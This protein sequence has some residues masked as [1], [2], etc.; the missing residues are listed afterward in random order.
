[1]SNWPSVGPAVPRRATGV[2]AMC[3]LLLPV[4]VQAQGLDTDLAGL[5]RENAELY[6]A[7]VTLGLGYAMGGGYFDSA[8]AMR[9]F[10]FDVG[11]RVMGALPSEASKTF[12]A[13]LPSTITFEGQTFPNPY[14]IQG[15][16]PA[17]PTATGQGPGIVLEPRA[18]FLE[19]LEGEGRNP[20]D[21]LIRFPEGADLPVIPYFVAHASMG[22][23]WGTEISARLMPEVELSDE[24]GGASAFGFGVK[25]TVSHWLAEPSPIDVAVWYG[26]QNVKVG[27]YLDGNTNQYGVMAGRGFGPLSLYGTGM[28]RT[29]SIGVSYTVENPGEIPGLPTD[30]EEVGFTSRLDSRLVFGAG[31]Q[32][33]LLLLNLSAQYTADEFSTLSL[34]VG[35]G[36]H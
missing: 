13:V 28:M 1:M 18:A 10:G 22:I 6:V 3:L 2:L 34:K 19:Y 24:M 8:A 15:G 35:F 9:R 21:Y 12:E 30:G 23:G 5:A 26:R 32:L 14:R 36:V 27:D 31:F 33:R 7:P 11:V 25:H 16:S 4:S 17:T 29:A 20:E